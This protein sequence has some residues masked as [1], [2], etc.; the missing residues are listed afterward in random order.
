VGLPAVDETY[1]LVALTVPPALEE[2]IVD[3]LLNL[4]NGSGFTSFPVSGH[5]SELAG[6]TLAEQVSGRKRQVRFEICVPG[7]A[8]D[9]LLSRLQQDFTGTG[10]RYCTA[11]VQ[12]QGKV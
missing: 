11:P 12:H 7:S 6:L 4:E 8:V 2:T 9:A 1:C 5:S 3:W 10:I